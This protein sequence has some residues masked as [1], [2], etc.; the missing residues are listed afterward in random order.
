MIET[1]VEYEGRKYEL[2]PGGGDNLCTKCEIP[3]SFKCPDSNLCTSE[4]GVYL[5]SYFE[6]EPEPSPIPVKQTFPSG[7]ILKEYKEVNYTLVFKD[8]S[9][10]KHCAFNSVPM[11]I[12]ISTACS[13]YPNHIWEVKQ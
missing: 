11:C 7:E 8:G 3:H 4:H 13:K 6:P 12:E 5:K 1:I 9:T 10:C 2:T